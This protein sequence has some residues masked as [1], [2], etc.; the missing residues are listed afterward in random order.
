MKKRENT[1]SVKNDLPENVVPISLKTYGM[2]SAP[3][4]SAHC[5]TE[6]FR[7][8]YPS[9]PQ[10]T[11]H[12]E[13]YESSEEAIDAILAYKYCELSE[14]G[15]FN[16][17][18]RTIYAR[19]PE[20][21]QL[22]PKLLAKHG[23]EALWLPI[24]S[25]L[26]DALHKSSYSSSDYRS[27][28]RWDEDCGSVCDDNV[29]LE[30]DSDM[31]QSIIGSQCSQQTGA[32]NATLER[33]KILRLSS[34]DEFICWGD[35]EEISSALTWAELGKTRLVRLPRKASE[36]Q[37]CAN[38]TKGDVKD[39]GQ[40][41]DLDVDTHTRHTQR[42]PH[43]E[44][45]DILLPRLSPTNERDHTLE[46]PAKSTFTWASF[47]EGDVDGLIPYCGHSSIK[48]SSD[49][50]DLS[51]TSIFSSID[52]LDTHLSEV[53]T[54]LAEQE[55]SSGFEI[56]ADGLSR[57][58]DTPLDMVFPEI[59]DCSSPKASVAPLSN[60]QLGGEQ[61]CSTSTAESDDILTD[62]LQNLTP[63]GDA[64]WE[65]KDAPKQHE[66]WTAL[67]IAES[68][69][70][71]SAMSPGQEHSDFDKTEIAMNHFSSEDD[72]API[73]S[74]MEAYSAIETAVRHFE[75]DNKERSQ[76]T[77]LTELIIPFEDM[78]DA[79]R[80]SVRQPNK[81]GAL[82]EILQARG[83]LGTGILSRGSEHFLPLTRTTS[84]PATDVSRLI[85]SLKMRGLDTN[86]S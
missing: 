83:T 74:P 76:P 45:N 35:D 16:P 36:G 64:F 69:R 19:L 82:V 51:D 23:L 10:R 48:Y 32:S 71:K 60:V 54:G 4:G 63:E 47:L 20:S 68:L 6:N 27:A 52:G 9:V 59:A 75:E 1:Q 41:S 77:V 34:D 81:V 38:I 3:P 85:P 44:R 33:D 73:L 58:L 49:E 25:H 67:L 86:A 13:T 57:K 46:L 28:T 80:P 5:S 42:G 21:G 43:A 17:Q 84:T 78:E 37:D 14:Y 11:A 18:N 26:E 65:I 79:H 12:V 70:R 22:D 66:D 62:V 2:P 29:F 7:V 55:R 53:G 40:S 8:E 30:V 50:I 61:L 72:V 24:N 39:H 56:T 31:A 15:I